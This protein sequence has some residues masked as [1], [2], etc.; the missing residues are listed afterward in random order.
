MSNMSEANKSNEVSLMKIPVFSGKEEDWEFF[1]PKF[2]AALAKKKL[3]KIL[4]WNGDLREDGYQ[5]ADNYIEE[6]KKD[7]IE[8]QE[9]NVEAAGLLLNCMDD[10]T[11]IGKVAFFQVQQFMDDEFAG[12]HFPNA[13]KALCERFDTKEIVDPVDPQQKYFD[14]K[15][16]DEEH[17]TP[18]MVKAERMKKEL[19][20]NGIDIIKDETEFMKHI[21]AKLP[22]GKED[23]MGPC[24]VEKTLIE[25]RMKSDEDCKLAGTHD[26]GS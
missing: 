13:W 16:D 21:L 19:K 17:P 11:E 1:K 5:W 15:M 6:K 4:T 8:M 10:S 3:S 26:E 7:E 22:K 18:F 24:Q 9:V 2:I 25:P 23:G 12:G 14:L 20:D